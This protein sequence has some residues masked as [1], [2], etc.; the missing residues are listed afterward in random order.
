MAHKNGYTEA[1]EKDLFENCSNYVVP[2]S[3]IKEKIEK[4]NRQ[5]K[6]WTEELSEPNCDF[7]NIDRNLKRIKN[8]VDILQKLESE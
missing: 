6:E 3:K 4:L 7:K 1:L 5:D 2:K 8:Q